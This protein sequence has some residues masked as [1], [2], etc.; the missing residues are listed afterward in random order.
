MEADA[1]FESLLVEGRR[2][3]TMGVVAKVNYTHTDMID[4]LITNPRATQNQLAAR[5]GYSVGWVS[6]VMASDAWK[7]LM[8]SRRAELVDPVLT[9]TL[10]ERFEGMTRLSLQRL[11]E[12]LEAPQVSD[13]VVLK[14]VEL[15]AKAM[16]IGGN[17]APPPAP[18]VDHLAALAQRLLVLQSQVRQGVFNGQTIEAEVVSVVG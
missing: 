2:A 12:K 9:A 4:F 11:Q 3:P 10:T 16:G 7:S 13:Q 14:A 1:D 15:G 5:Y 17:A 6:N 18:P 8:A